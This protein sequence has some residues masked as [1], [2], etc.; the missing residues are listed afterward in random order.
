MRNSLSVRSGVLIWIG[1]AIQAF[2]LYHVHACSGVTE[3]GV[4]GLTLL[5]E[6]WFEISPAVSGALLNMVC[7]LIGWRV[8]GGGFIVCSFL[9]TVGFCSTYWI[10]E[11]YP[12]FWP[13]L[14]EMPLVAA[15]VGALFIGIGVGICVRQGAAPGGDDALAMSISHVSGIGIEKVYLVSDLI[16]L[17]MSIS[18]IPLTRICYSL[19]TVV[20][21][22]QIIGMV[23]RLG[24]SK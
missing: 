6:R 13:Q 16:V 11:Q 22:G 2:G 10:C 12:Q 20:L 7:Y 1:S 19:I 23:Q 8:L 4:L 21:S 15:V 18:Y 9:S 14:Y 17:G 24:G 5:L 3:G